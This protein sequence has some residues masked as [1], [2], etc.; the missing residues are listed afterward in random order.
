MPAWWNLRGWAL[1]AAIS[2]VIATGMTIG[3]IGG[4][5]EVLAEP[6]NLGP[7]PSA[8]PEAIDAAVPSALPVDLSSTPSGH[9]WVTVLTLVQKRTPSMPCWL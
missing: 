6:P 5:A 9:R 4:T 1:R 3:A 2:A 7:A 8:L